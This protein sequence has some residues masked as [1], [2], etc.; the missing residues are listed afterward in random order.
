MLSRLVMFDSA[1]LCNVA[2]QAPLSMG[3]FRQEYWSGWPIPPP[4]DLS[5]PGTKTAS[6]VCPALRAD[7][8]PDKL[9]GKPLLFPRHI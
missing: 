9:L 7:S 1:T 2:F 3:L 8:L 5:D 4:G 6:P